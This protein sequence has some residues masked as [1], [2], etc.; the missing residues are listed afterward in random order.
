MIRSAA[1]LL[2]HRGNAPLRFPFFGRGV[3]IRWNAS[4]ASDSPGNSSGLFASFR[5]NYTLAVLEDRPM[6]P[7]LR[8][9]SSSVMFLSFCSVSAVII[10]ITW[11]LENDEGRGRGGPRSLKSLADDFGDV[12]VVEDGGTSNLLPGL[13]ALNPDVLFDPEGLD[14]TNKLGDMKLPSWWIHG[15]SLLSATLNINST[16]TSLFMAPPENP[17]LLLFN[18]VLFYDIAR[19]AARLPGPATPLL[20]LASFLEYSD[21]EMLVCLLPTPA[22]V[23]ETR[24]ALFW[25]VLENFVGRALAAPPPFIASEEDVEAW[26]AAFSAHPWVLLHDAIHDFEL[27]ERVWDHA[28]KRRGVPPGGYGR[29]GGGGA[30]GVGESGALY[31]SP[32][33]ADSSNS[34]S[35]SSSSSSSN[36]S[37]LS[38]GREDVDEQ[39]SRNSLISSEF[40]K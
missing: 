6:Y 26:G 23:D 2:Q 39:N 37:A 28:E 20:F 34:S 35:S 18:I 1:R 9:I 31:R 38:I 30:G 24:S 15:S 36:N 7:Q 25:T 12:Y 11:Y 8:I 32:N 16:L 22:E 29:V 40:R 19:L 13:D 14:A 10:F 5:E 17:A 3:P 4:Y 27:A 33:L 21:V